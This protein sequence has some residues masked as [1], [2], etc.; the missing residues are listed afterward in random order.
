MEQV[1]KGLEESTN[2]SATLGLEM[3]QSDAEMLSHYQDI[4]ALL[5][6][7]T[8]QARLPFFVKLD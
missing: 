4:K 5:Q 6:D 7:R 2:A 8:P 1:I 3:D